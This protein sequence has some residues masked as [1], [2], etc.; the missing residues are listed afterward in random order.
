MTNRRQFLRTSVS[1]SAL[2]LANGLLSRESFARTGAGI[3]IHKAIFDDRYVE[4]RIFAEAMGRF[5]VPVQPLENG[6]VTDL[7]RSARDALRRRR[8]AAIAGTTQFGPMFAFE[9]L[10]REHRMRVVLRIEHQARD[11]GT[12][13][14]VMTGPPETLALAEDLR[15]QGADWPVLMAALAA[16]CRSDGCAPAEHCAVTA[17][18]PPILTKPRSRRGKPGPESVIHYYLPHAIREGHGVPWDG[19]LFS[20]VIA[21]PAAA[22]TSRQASADL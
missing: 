6:D 2:P 10:G 8:Q 5:G 22:L 3:R 1:V 17:G 18:A 7:W 21:P 11:D 9:Q 14:H 4:A 13:E 15:L 12:I 16:H 20:W 19:P